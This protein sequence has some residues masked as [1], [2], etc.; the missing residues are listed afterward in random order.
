MVMWYSTEMWNCVSVTLGKVHYRF[1]YIEHIIFIPFENVNG[2][3]SYYKLS[4]FF[5]LWMRIWWSQCEIDSVDLC[6]KYLKFID[7]KTG[8]ETRPMKKWYSIWIQTLK[9]AVSKSM[10]A[11]RSRRWEWDRKLPYLIWLKNVPISDS[12]A[13]DKIL[14]SHFMSVNA[15][16]DG[17]HFFFLTH[18]SK[19]LGCI[20][21]IV[22]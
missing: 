9:S 15:S 14:T 2:I 6:L 11:H 3:P 7:A 5:Y 8:Q 4:A 16:F 17:R 19:S 20:L 22:P 1:L 10:F 12:L 21:H 13:W 18:I